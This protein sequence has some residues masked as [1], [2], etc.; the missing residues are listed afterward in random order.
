[1]T[2]KDAVKC[3]AFARPN[4]YA[5]PVSAVLPEAALARIL[6]RLPLAP[7]TTGTGATAPD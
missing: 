3:A 5:L 7:G 6:A 4:W 2:E 1:M